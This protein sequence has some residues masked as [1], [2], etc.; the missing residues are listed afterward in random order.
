MSHG[1]RCRLCGGAE[2][3]P[4]LPLGDLP[5][6]NAFLT[7]DELDE[8]EPRHPLTLLHC[9]DCSLVQ[10]QETVSPEALFHEYLY[11]SSVSRT[12]LDHAREAADRLVDELGLGTDAL[13]VE[14][15][16]NDGYMLQYFHQRQIPVLGI[17]PARNLNQLAAAEGIET[18]TAFFDEEVARGLRHRGRAADLVIANNVLAHVPEVHGFVAGIRELL[19]PGGLATIEVPYVKCMIDRKEYDTIYH[20]H[21]SYFSLTALDRLLGGH[22]LAIVDVERLD[23]HGGSL[24]LFVRR[25]GEG[26]P[27]PKVL[28]L[29]REEADWVRDPDYY[30]GFKTAFESLGET[31]EAFFRDLKSGSATI[32]AYGAAAKGTMFTNLFGIDRRF[33]DFVV[34]RNTYKQGR[35]LPGSHVPIHGPERLLAEEPDFCLLLVWN[36]ADEIIEQEREYLDRGGRFVVPVPQPRILRPVRPA[37]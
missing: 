21:V 24:R 15:G 37:S 36:L 19:A 1:P 31:L 29:L 18:L 35:F 4:F 12:M 8:P 25:E 7:E 10:L 2:P 33:L 28:E 17:D 9:P 22:R 26:D 6:A 27:S 23:I 5:L 34:D 3:W 20:E 11:L 16:S 32:A 30:R 14:L 13:V